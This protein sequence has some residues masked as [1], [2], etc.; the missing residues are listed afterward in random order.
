MPPP[1]E[2]WKPVPWL[3]NMIPASHYIDAVWDNVRMNN[4]AAHFV[5]AFLDLH[6]K[7]DAAKAAYLTEDWLG[8]AEGSARGLRLE[9]L[10]KGA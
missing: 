5:T 8:F 6:L 7:G 10:A 4:I 2:A 3:N 9:T 1:Q